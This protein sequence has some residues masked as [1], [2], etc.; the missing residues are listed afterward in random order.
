[1]KECAMSGLLKLLVVP[2]VVASSLLFGDAPQAEAQGFGIQIYSGYPS[3]YGGG[4]G[5]GYGGY[6]GYGF[7]SYN[8]YYG[9]SYYR[10]YGYNVFYGS[11]SFYRPYHHHHHHHHCH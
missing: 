11:P 9:S 4:Y 8:T 6:G 3:Y 7:G 10:P 5:G 2:A 1:M